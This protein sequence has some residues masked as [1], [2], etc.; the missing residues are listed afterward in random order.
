MKA[1]FFVLTFLLSTC[2]LYSQNK[3][4][5][6]VTVKFPDFVI[7]P[8]VILYKNGDKEFEG[9][10]ELAFKEFFEYRSFNLKFMY[11][12]NKFPPTFVSIGTKNCKDKSEVIQKI[13]KKVEKELAFKIEKSYVNIDLWHFEVKD[14][15]KFNKSF[16]RRHYSE[17]T[18]PSYKEQIK[19]KPNIDTFRFHPI[20]YVI[21]NSD[22]WPKVRSQFIDDT[23]NYKISIQM[24]DYLNNPDYTCSLSFSP[25]FFNE[26]RN[27]QDFAEKFLKNYGLQVTRKIGPIEH[28]EIYRIH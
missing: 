14:T 12:Y 22:Y 9:L 6:K 10:S 5:C 8:K 28:Y 15:V 19:G 27:F 23:I 11:E 21:A 2:N 24:D 26:N 18:F 3:D 25:L 4:N 7:Q 17:Y 20:D 1:P 16:N 13:T